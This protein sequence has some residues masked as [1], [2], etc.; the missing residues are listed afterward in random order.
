MP[1]GVLTPSGEQS[2]IQPLLA[3][4]GGCIRQIE[5]AN[6]MGLEDASIVRRWRNYRQIV[7]VRNEAGQWVCPI[8]QFAHK[9]KRVM[10]GIRD[11]LAELSF[12]SEW[13]PLIFFLSRMD[14][15]GG[16]SPLDSLRAG[17]IEAAIKAA[18]QYSPRKNN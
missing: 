18:R 2:P 16:H 1:D 13:E 3:A 10:L 7:S 4:R 8:W 12:E 15:L 5:V 6:M 11:C 9:H 14:S 17:K